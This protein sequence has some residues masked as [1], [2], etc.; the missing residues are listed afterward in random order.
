MNGSWRGVGLGKA[1]GNQQARG[2]CQRDQQQRHRNHTRF[3]HHL[4]S[5]IGTTARIDMIDAPEGVDSNAARR[6]P[7]DA[8][9]GK[10]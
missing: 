1:G 3:A 7:I 9:Q 6:W 4:Y 8:A 2:A 10:S 5:L